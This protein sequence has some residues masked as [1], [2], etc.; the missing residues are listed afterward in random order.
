[1]KMHTYNPPTNVPT[2]DYIGQGHYSKMKVQIKVT[3][4]CCVPTTP[5]QYP[6]QILTSYTLHF[7]RYSL[8]KI[9]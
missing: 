7:P 9:L 2:K 1:M 6:Y 4:W 3:P 5:N 8:D